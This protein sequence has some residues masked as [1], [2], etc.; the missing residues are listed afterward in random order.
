M[1]L[2]TPEKSLQCM[3]GLPRMI[4]VAAFFCIYKY[5]IC[6]VRLGLNEQ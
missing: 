1:D 2:H 6:M 3:R 4:P 5:D